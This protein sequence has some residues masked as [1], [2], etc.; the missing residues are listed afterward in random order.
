MTLHEGE[1]PKGEG[2]GEDESNTAHKGEV[3]FFLRTC[4]LGLPK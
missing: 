3:K 2:E 4:W 1:G